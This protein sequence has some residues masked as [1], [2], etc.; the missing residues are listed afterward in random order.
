[1]N[2]HSFLAKGFADS[3]KAKESWEG[4]KGGQREV[5]IRS[6]EEEEPNFIPWKH[7]VV[8]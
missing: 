2:S 8:F 6:P 7:V 3:W 5:E 1:M 4:W